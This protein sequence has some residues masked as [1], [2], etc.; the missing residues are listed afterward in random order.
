MFIID[1]H[2]KMNSWFLKEEQVIIFVYFLIVW[3]IC[4]LVYKIKIC[5]YHPSRKNPRCVCN[6]ILHY[7]WISRILF[8]LNFIYYFLK[9]FYFK[10]FKFLLFLLKEGWSVATQNLSVTILYSY[11]CIYDQR[12]VYNVVFVSCGIIFEIPDLS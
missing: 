3:S 9:K 1:Q 11:P 8:L 6:F 5:F 12:S 10:F 4:I 7:N 2:Q